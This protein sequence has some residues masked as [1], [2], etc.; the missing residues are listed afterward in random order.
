MECVQISAI[1]MKLKASGPKT[2]RKIQ[3]KT[4]MALSLL[5][6][7]CAGMGIQG[8]LVA[9][10]GGCPGPCSRPH[11]G[12]A[13]LALWHCVPTLLG[14]L[15]GVCCEHLPLPPQPATRSR[16][17]GCLYDC[18]LPT[19]RATWHPQSFY[20]GGN[21]WFWSRTPARWPV[22]SNVLRVVDADVYLS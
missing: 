7:P 22:L 9:M 5:S 10:R 19:A 3:E 12:A 20:M 1:L 16:G 15:G 13:L 4:Q 6:S 2:P 11:S 17:K 18:P 8:V 14:C 21:W